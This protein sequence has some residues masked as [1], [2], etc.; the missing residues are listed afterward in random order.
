[1][2]KMIALGILCVS[3][4][5]GQ[6]FAATIT[7]NPPDSSLVFRVNHDLGYTIGSFGDFSATVELGDQPGQVVSAKAQVQTASIST[8]NDV[9]DQG[10]RSAL[11]LDSEKF[12]QAT[13]E[14]IKVEGDEVSGTLTVKGVAHPVTLKVQEGAP[15]GKLILK[16]AFN[17]NDFGVSYNKVSN[18][19][20]SIGES[21]E[22]II[23]LKV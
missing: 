19:K 13:F 20:K 10:L 16:G 17:R 1:M 11:F 6:A 3:A 9:R 7:A 21:V 12:P 5:C 14:S 18:K 23:E 2:R 15:A 8:G 22:L 4:V